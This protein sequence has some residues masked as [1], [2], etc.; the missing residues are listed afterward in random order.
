MFFV[1]KINKV[2]Y[3]GC[4]IEFVIELFYKDVNIDEI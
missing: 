3:I 2:E 4:E 1:C